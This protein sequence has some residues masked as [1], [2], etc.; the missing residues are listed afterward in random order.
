MSEPALHEVAL[1][2][3]RAYRFAAIRPRLT[4]DGIPFTLHHGGGFAHIA[5]ILDDDHPRIVIPKGAQLGLTVA[6]VLKAIDHAAY[7]RRGMRKL[8]GILYCFPTDDDV[9]DFSTARFRRVLDENPA[10]ARLVGKTNS[11]RVRQVGGTP[12][13][14]IHVGEVGR[15]QKSQ[16]KLKSRPADDLFLDERDEMSQERVDAIGHR[17]DASPDPHRTDLS[18][19]TVP[20]YGID[21]DWQSSDQHVWMRRCRRCGEWNCLDEAWPECLVLDHAGRSPYFRCDR[22]HEELESD[23]GDWIPARQEADL[24]YRGYWLSQLSAGIKGAER[25]ALELD[26]ATRAGRMKEFHRQVLGRPYAEV[27]E[28]LTP[29]LVRGACDPKVPSE[30]RSAGPTTMGVDPGAHVIHW[31]VAERV[32][33][34]DGRTL[35]YGIC[36]THDELHDLAVRFGVQ[37]GVIDIGAEKRWVRAFL[38][39]HPG[40]FGCLYSPIKGP[41]RWDGIQQVVHVDRTE[42]LDASHADVVDRRHRFPRWTAYFEKH[43]VPQL[44]NLARKVETDEETGVQSAKWVV[45][46]GVK[47]DHF[48]HAFNLAVVGLT[49]VGLP[50]RIR[51]ARAAV[52]RQRKR[53][54]RAGFMGR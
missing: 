25:I 38:D 13:S 21:L 45:R 24:S 39:D 43:V 51:R 34:A 35:A 9:A 17:L 19:P 11:V 6:H 44:C 3:S 1:A 32:T 31:W 36:K 46:G 40:W 30:A 10:L 49:R 53:G 2:N 33:D 54:R 47:N 29:E 22:C 15:A 7:G 20:D 41:Y 37:V 14:F 12:I 18:T 27:S 52:R 42:S 8:R 50:E 4:V 28:V 5:K 48:R 16:S 23:L 26:E